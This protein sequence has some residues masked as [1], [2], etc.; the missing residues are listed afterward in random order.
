MRHTNEDEEMYQKVKNSLIGQMFTVLMKDNLLHLFSKTSDQKD[1]SLF[2]FNIDI[3]KCLIENNM[4]IDGRYEF[5]PRQ[6]ITQII[7]PILKLKH[8]YENNNFPPA[9]FR[10]AKRLIPEI[11]NDIDNINCDTEQKERLKTFIFYWFNNP[12]NQNVLKIDE[13]YFKIFNLP[14]IKSFS[15][16]STTGTTDTTVKTDTTIKTTQLLKLTQC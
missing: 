4:M 13:K 3:I 9:Y 5:N 12:K 11:E 1:I 16:G 2:P 10:K 14:K 8:E 7:E 15:V 6:I